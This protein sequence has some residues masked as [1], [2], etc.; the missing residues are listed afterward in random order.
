MSS[1]DPQGATLSRVRD[2]LRES[3]P[4][5]WSFLYFFCLLS[6]YYV[7]R[8]VRDA[9]GA[10]SDVE[11]VFPAAMIRYFAEHGI[12]LAELILQVLATCTFVLILVAQPLYGALVSRYP[13]RVFMPVLFGFFIACLLVF[14]ALFD[15]DIGGR[16]MAFFL[17][18]TVFNVFSVS[19]FWSFMADVFSN[20]EARRYYGYI[21]AAGTVGAFVGPIITGALAERVGLANLMLVSGSFLSVCVLCIV[22]LRRWAVQREIKVGRDNES[23][24][25]G[26]VLA[27]LK[28]VVREPLLRWMA[29][30]VFLGVGV[31]QLLYN[32]QNAIARASFATAEARAEY[33][34]AIDIAVAVLTLVVQLFV[35]RT[36]LSRFGL[37]PTLMIP[38][39]ALLLGFAVLAASPLPMLVAGVL[40]VTRSNE[41]SLMKPGRE[42]IY[43]R[44]DRQWRYK[45]GAAIDTAFYRGGEVSFSWIYK[46]LSLFGAQIVFA[47]GLLL[48]SAMTIS[49][50]RL[51]R[52]EKR[53]PAER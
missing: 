2:A 37:W 44:V 1:A 49:A 39:V 25:G 6:G 15:R 9:M 45:A 41:F 14:Y 31:G 17:W 35:T 4:L 8:P 38:M 24:M 47:A 30:M 7:L 36:L 32:Q 42:T 48:A 27:G 10:S 53:L 22:Q 5:L 51:L 46:A 29:L 18:V 28:L 16:G 50:W 12:P 34:A 3:P 26:A 23:A 43:T 52:E 19:V 40:V 20:A 33:Y 11:A 13:R 21:G